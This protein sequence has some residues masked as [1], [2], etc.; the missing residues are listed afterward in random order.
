MRLSLCPDCEKRILGGECLGCRLRKSK[1]QIARL[2]AIVDK[3]PKYT[4]TGESFVPGVD[5]CWAIVT[6][7]DGEDSARDIHDED[8]IFQM[9]RPES[10]WLVSWGGSDYGCA[11]KFFSTRAAAEAAQKG[12]E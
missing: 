4:D 3:L 10:R 7:G 11:S 2:Q 5:P 9:I 1:N 12:K 8:D 6:G